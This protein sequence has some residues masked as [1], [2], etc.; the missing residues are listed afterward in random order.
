MIGR[1]VLLIALTPMIATAQAPAARL[2]RAETAY[3]AG[4]FAVAEAEFAA[5]L[6][7]LGPA[8]GAVLVDLGH[9][10]HQL[11]RLPD[12]MLLY[13]RAALRRPDDPHLARHLELTARDLGL[14]PP[15]PVPT[16][17]HIAALLDRASPWQ[18]LT[19]AALLQT[20]GLVTLL[21]SRR[22]RPRRLA[23]LALVLGISAASRVVWTSA[24]PPMHQ[25]VALRELTIRTEP[26][27]SLPRLVALPAG[28][29]VRLAESSDR[30]ARII[31]P[32]AS[33]WVDRTALAI[34]E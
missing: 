30:W 18:W 27:S 10:A 32:G 28:T 21:A 29:T 6:D 4:D 3:A 14:P 5:V 8:D 9:C 13:R 25:A 15:A 20:V 17:A 23:A 34:V 24:N 16:T 11:G 7:V 33:G 12:A 2:A 19:F 22:R 31:H 26:H 1:L